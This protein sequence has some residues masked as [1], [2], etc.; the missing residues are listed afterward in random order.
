MPSLAAPGLPR[1]RLP[2]PEAVLAEFALPAPTGT[3]GL[4]A[5]PGYRILRTLEVDAYEA[6]IPPSGIAP[7]ILPRAAPPDDVFRGT[8]RRA[9]KLSLAAAP[10]ESFS[11]LAKLIPTLAPH[12]KMAR[13]PG[14]STDAT[15][16]RVAEE[17]RNVRL[18][19]FLYAASRE[20]DNDFHLIVGRRPR[21]AQL[22]MTVEISGLPP[23]TSPAF[24][25]LNRARRAYSRFF[26]PHLPGASYDF[27]DPPIPVTIEGS[28]FFDLSHAKGSRPGPSRL[29][30]HMPV[31]WEIHPVSKIAFEP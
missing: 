12:G 30:P 26:G 11:D 16:D 10:T 1:S 8:A 3:R 7:L 13:H 15:N 27:Y 2:P 9:A 19:A 6:P 17:R 14:L 29:R 24:A 25:A 5:A 4:A 31:L 20:D 21:Q 23:R 18:G 22:Y 28:L